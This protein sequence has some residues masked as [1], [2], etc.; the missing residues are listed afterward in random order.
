MLTKEELVEYFKKDL[1]ATETVGIEIVDITE[2]AATCRLTVRDGHRNA[3]GGVMG[4]VTFTLGDFTA[5]LLVNR[6]G[7]RTVSLSASISY[8]G[9]CKGNTL[10]AVA[11]AIKEGR[12]VATAEVDISDE[13]G[14]KVAFMVV[15]GF[16]KG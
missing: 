10:I 4:G 6:G 2:E 13:L 3:D 1:F 7:L 16:R 14:N 9:V 8:L 11:R 15:N 5:A 12:S